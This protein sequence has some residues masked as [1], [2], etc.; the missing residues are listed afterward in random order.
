MKKL[1]LYG[2]DYLS[3]VTGTAA[4]VVWLCACS[5]SGQQALLIMGITVGALFLPWQRMKTAARVL[6]VI[7]AAALFRYGILLTARLCPEVPEWS[8]WLGWGVAIWALTYIGRRPLRAAVLPL[9]LALMSGL[10]LSFVFSVPSFDPAVEWNGPPW[11]RVSTGVLI[12]LGCALGSMSEDKNSTATLAGALTGVL[13]WGGVAFLPL[14]LWSRPALESLSAVL[15][16]GWSL[17]PLPCSEVWLGA[18]CAVAALW[19][20]GRSVGALMKLEK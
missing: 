5:V 7:S 16:R 9:G 3:A 15:L 14:L 18:L 6:W 20:C 1:S 4:S 13:L 2:R 11:Q 10:V 12:L 17:L 19:Q 8:I